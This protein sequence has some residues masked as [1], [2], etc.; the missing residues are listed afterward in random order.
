MQIRSL[1][2][3]ILSAGLL[4]LSPCVT[5]DESLPIGQLITK[6][7]W[8]VIHAATDGPRYTIKTLDGNVVQEDLT[9]KLLAT[10]YPEL[11]NALTR[12]IATPPVPTRVIE[13]DHPHPIP[14]T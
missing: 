9:D 5:A 13:R 10:L 4:T 12:G 11:H 6:K 1:S 3:L 14:R 7:H 2:L 8:I